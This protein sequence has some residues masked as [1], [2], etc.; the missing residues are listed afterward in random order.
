MRAIILAAGKGVR[1]NGTAGKLPKCLVKV[2]ELTLVER[3]IQAL[4]SAGI[5]EIVIVIGHGADRVRQTCGPDCIYVENTDYASTNSLFSLWLARDFLRD[6]FVVLNADVL[7]H[8]QLLEDLLLSSCEDALLV[9]YSDGQ[10]PPLGE[11]E[12]KVCVRE[13]RV[14]D[15]SKAID[16]R[17][18]DGENVGI[19][20][21]GPSGAR[22]LVKHME[23]LIANGARRDWAPRAFLEFARELPLHAIGTRGRPWI[24][25]DFPEDYLRAVNEILPLIIRDE[26]DGEARRLAL[27]TSGDERG[28][29]QHEL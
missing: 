28:R 22:V 24:E 6:G 21:F 10:A 29:V 26:R 1:L 4:R 5:D 8:P 18:A 14:A 3:Q 17:E 25:I 15:I 20:K 2:G 19:V 12:M 23:A 11:E 7:F 27:A 9:A 13:G 16:P